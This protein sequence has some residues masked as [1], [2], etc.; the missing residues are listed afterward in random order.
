MSWN[1]RVDEAMFLASPDES[2]FVREFGPGFFDDQ[3]DHV[4][5]AARHVSAGRVVSEIS[6]RAEP[7]S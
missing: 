4:R 3:T 2:G 6:M 5:S 1:S 7:I